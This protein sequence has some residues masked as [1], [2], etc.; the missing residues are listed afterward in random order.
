LVL[1]FSKNSSQKIIRYCKNNA[2]ELVFINDEFLTDFDFM[3]LEKQVHGFLKFIILLPM[4]NFIF[5]LTG[6]KTCQV[7]KQLDTISP[8]EI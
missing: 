5:D 4:M 7:R 2:E 8:M 3:L 6:L 1:H